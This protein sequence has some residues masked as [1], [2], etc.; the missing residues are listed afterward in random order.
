MSFDLALQSYF[1]G[2]TVPMD[3]EKVMSV[4]RRYCPDAVCQFGGYMLTFAD[5]S[6]LEMI[7]RGLEF[8][9]EFMALGFQKGDL[10]P[11][12][13]EFMYDVARAGNMTMFNPQAADH[14]AQHFLYLMSEAQAPELPENDPSYQVV[15]TSPAHLAELLAAGR[16][17]EP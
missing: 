12:V 5:G 3:R 1:A 7:A 11:V 15:C 16:I 10:A 6:R 17:A 8:E 13:I 9:G 14:G 4:L 2:E